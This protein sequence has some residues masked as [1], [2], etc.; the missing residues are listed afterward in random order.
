MSFTVY[1]LRTSSNT[2]YIG[3]TN[4]LEKR[5]K[6]HQNKTSKSAKYMK[7]FSSFKLVYSEEYTSRT[8]AM[9]REYQLKHWPRT[10]K[11]ALVSSIL[12]SIDHFTSYFIGIPLPEKYQ[13]SFEDLLKKVSQINP[14]F[15]PTYSKTPHITVCYLDKQPKANLSKITEKVKSYLE[16]LKGAELTIGGFGYF[17]ENHPRILFLDVRYPKS[18]Q[19]FNK[20][21]TKSLSI[22]SATHNNLPFYPHMTVAWVGDPKAQQ[23]FKAH[24]PNIKS[25]LDKI[26]WPLKITEVVLY[27]VDSTKQPEY[28]KK[29]ISLLV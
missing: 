10:Q 28:Q 20:T 13:K 21:I 25:I 9:K 23:A 17:G 12:P 4:N 1:I 7:Y 11:E 24:Q 2:L 5:L 18:L 14:L 27:G 16:K 8:E 6:E 22:Y 29:L 26:N 19:E 15:K 3:Q